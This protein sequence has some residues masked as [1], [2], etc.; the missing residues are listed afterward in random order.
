M[1]TCSK[2]TVSPRDVQGCHRLSKKSSDVICRFV[3]KKPVEEALENWK[4][5]RN[6]DKNNAGLPS[7][8]GDIYI[9]THL[10]PYNAKLAYHCRQLKRDGYVKKIS[11][12]KGIIRVL[13]EDEGNRGN[14]EHSSWKTISHLRDLHAIF[15][16]FVNQ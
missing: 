2:T 12:R 15:P 6:F 10:T 9:N 7:S 14:V 1:N 5:L 3:S 16:H 11:T 4:E 8:T 13:V